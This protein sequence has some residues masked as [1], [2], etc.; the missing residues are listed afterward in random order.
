[1]S[2]RRWLDVISFGLLVL[3]GAAISSALEAQPSVREQDDIAATLAVEGSAV[4]VR[5]RFLQPVAT[6]LAEVTATINERPLGVPIIEPYP[7]P[8]AQTLALLLLDVTDL[9]REAQI[10]RDKLSLFE[11]ADHAG[12]DHRIAMAVYAERPQLIVPADGS[13]TTLQKIVMGAAPRS[14]FVDLGHVLQ[15]ATEVLSRI[16]VDRR[17]IFVLTDGHSDD[18]LNPDLLI[19]HAKRDNISLNFILTPS[20]RSVDLNAL[21]SIARATGGLVVGEAERAAFLQAPFELLDSGATVRFPLDNARRYIWERN[22]EVKVVFHYGDRQMELAAPASVP[23]AGF[24]ETAAYLRDNHPIALG[25]SG[26][27]ILLL[28]GIAIVASRKR[29]NPLDASAASERALGQSMDAG[30]PV[31]RSRR[32]SRPL[33]VLEDVETGKVYSVDGP[34][35][36]LGRDASSDIVLDDATV[37]RLHAVLQQGA[38]GVFSIENR[39][40]INPTL[41]N[42]KK[43]DT[44][45]LSD[46]DVISL[47]SK[48]LRLRTSLPPSDQQS[49]PHTGSHDALVQASGAPP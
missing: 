25:A 46:G 24:G 31:E 39:S 34:F 22:A 15:N 44:A 43:I 45:T 36:Q 32:A 19:E 21:Q 4:M 5:W 2:R 8:G 38:Y 9:R 41:V 10:R 49:A 13:A 48:K 33:A 29:R 35:V 14:A 7:G 26:G 27:A 17:G 1:M 20:N 28:G 30:R 40:E 3:L 16:S 47:G 18:P 37:S 6:P 23:L 42:D 11:I 12:T